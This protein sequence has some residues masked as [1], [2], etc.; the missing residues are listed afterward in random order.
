M[1]QCA[2]WILTLL[3]LTGCWHA[4][5]DT[6]S[7][8]NRAPGARELTKLPPAPSDDKPRKPD[9]AGQTAGVVEAVGL[10]DDATQ[11][12]KTQ[13]SD[14]GQVSPR[15]ALLAIW[16]QLPEVSRPPFPEALFAQWRP[17]SHLSIMRFVVRARHL[18]VDVAPCLQS[19]AHR[20]TGVQQEPVAAFLESETA[21]HPDD[22]LALLSAATGRYRSGY[23][24]V[25][26]DVRLGDQTH[27]HRLCFLAQYQR[28]ARQGH[29]FVPSCAVDYS[30]IVR[31]NPDFANALR[32]DLSLLDDAVSGIEER[33][34]SQRSWWLTTRSERE[35]IQA[36]FASHPASTWET[37]APSAHLLAPHVKVNDKADTL[38][39]LA[40][41]SDAK[42]S[43]AQAIGFLHSTG[44]QPEHFR[45]SHLLRAVSVV[46]QEL[47][48]AAF[49]HVVRVQAWLGR[50]AQSQGKPPPGLDLANGL[51]LFGTMPTTDA[52]DAVEALLRKFLL[53]KYSPSDAPSKAANALL[54]L[55][56]APP[57]LRAAALDT[58]LFSL[59]YADD[60]CQARGL[61]TSVKPYPINTLLARLDGVVHA[62]ASGHIREARHLLMGIEA[63]GL[64]I[65]S[66]PPV[67]EGPGN[68]FTDLFYVLG[69]TP[70][71][72]YDAL[73]EA[74]S[75]LASED[76]E[77]NMLHIINVGMCRRAPAPLIAGHLH[78][79]YQALK[80]QNASNEI[81]SDISTRLTAGIC[82]AY[83]YGVLDERIQ[84]VMD[85]IG[86]GSDAAGLQVYFD[87]L[88][89]PGGG[90]R[91]AR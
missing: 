70:P 26:D 73:R 49:D 80:K 23:D 18:G 72:R 27:M 20:V 84:R 36:F 75:L 39:A 17:A 28:L 31:R 78:R 71:D 69:Y 82:R 16:M 63:D 68:L 37:L 10:P 91:R 12:P 34:E 24:R 58:T 25:F 42:T 30:D 47:V 48:Q 60:H 79:M 21:Y 55:C 40:K 33:P 88:V 13:P 38:R 3:L 64:G 57:E 1:L 81:S 65:T 5:P 59:A 54:S 56:Q 66:C 22:L 52:M 41:L 44:P 83:T 67:S 14:P 61:P 85:A 7:A 51:E 4:M 87:D 77:R 89:T 19:L 46:P 32:G 76:P 50:K 9:A 86:R 8:P 62:S 43:V 15:R 2:A 90:R 11:A 45:M 29:F 74:A 35:A 53:G 6:S